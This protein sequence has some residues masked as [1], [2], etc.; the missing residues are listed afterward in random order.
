MGSIG[1]CLDNALTESFFSS[2]Q[3]ELHDRRS[4]ATCQQLANAIFEWIEAWYNPRRRHPALGYR[5]PVEYENLQPVATAA[6][7][8]PNRTRPRNWGK[9]TRRWGP[10]GGNDPLHRGRDRV[11]RPR[12]YVVSGT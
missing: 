3:V 5:S 4:G 12:H 10:F 7:S 9:V 1:D 6:A 8:S 11:V 2:L